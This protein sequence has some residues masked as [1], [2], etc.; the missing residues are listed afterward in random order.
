MQVK[1]PT[2][3]E[4]LK[5]SEAHS[6]HSV[7]PP[8]LYFPAAHNCELVLAVVGFDPAGADEQAV[9][10]DEALNCPAPLQSVHEVVPPVDA[11]PAGQVVQALSVDEVQDA[12]MYFPAGQYVHGPQAAC[13]VDAVTKPVAQAE[14]NTAPPRA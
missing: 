3:P 5:V 11:F 8:T 13:P 7:R 6:T 12:E 2:A 1:Q 9:L 10:P 14:H 4:S